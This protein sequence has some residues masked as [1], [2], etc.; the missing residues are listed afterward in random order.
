[1]SRPSLSAQPRECRLKNVGRYFAPSRAHPFETVAA[2]ARLSYRY[3]FGALRVDALTLLT[4]E[5]PC[6][7]AAHDAHA[8]G[9]AV[10]RTAGPDGSVTTDAAV[11]QLARELC[12]PELL[13]LALYHLALGDASASTELISADDH[14]VAYGRA[15]LVRARR[16][17]VDTWL[18]DGACA[19]CAPLKACLE[20]AR[21]TSARDASAALE[22]WDVAA[23]GLCALCAE[24]AFRARRTGRQRVWDELP[25][26]FGLPPWDKISQ[27]TD[28]RR[29]GKHRSSAP[30]NNSDSG[31]VQRN[32]LQS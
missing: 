23:L 3:G 13:P 25:V 17:L 32:E 26:Y 14:A 20:D 10:I 5:W 19:G 31:L 28:E 16:Q 7:L 30:G 15:A 1:V 8:P 27:A 24:R 21:A 6:T 9:S 2:V 18:R 4:H 22:P 29:W 12:L 11:V